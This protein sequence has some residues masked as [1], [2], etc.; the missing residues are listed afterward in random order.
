MAGASGVAQRLA[1]NA[2]AQSS[3]LPKAGLGVPGSPPANDAAAASAAPAAAPAADAD[4]PVEA[5]ASPVKAAPG[6]GG[7]GRGEEIDNKPD[8]A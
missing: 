1:A 8:C 4:P 3:A 7:A 6:R 5:G 2:T